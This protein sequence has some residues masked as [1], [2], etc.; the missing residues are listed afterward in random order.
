MPF[1]WR[2]T[3]FSRIFISRWRLI[4]HPKGYRIRVSFFCFGVVIAFVM[5]YGFAKARRVVFIHDF[6]E[7]KAFLRTSVSIIQFQG[8]FCVGFDPICCCFCTVRL[9]CGEVVFVMDCVG[10]DF[11][12]RI[13][14]SFF[15]LGVN[16]V[17]CNY[18]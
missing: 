5:D 11:S 1:K 17:S 9:C 16:V 7:G 3:G 8:D 18:F 12:N 14:R 15:C 10:V 4:V 13:R 2:S 6:W